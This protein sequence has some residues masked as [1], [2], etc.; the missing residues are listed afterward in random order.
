MQAKYPIVGTKNFVR[1]V[2]GKPELDPKSKHDDYRCKCKIS[3]PNYKIFF[4]AH[5]IDEIQCVWIGLRQ[6]RVEI[7]EFEK[8]TSMKCEYLYFQEFEE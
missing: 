2:I 1:V 3:A 7:A 8:K 4:Y 5:G 6:I